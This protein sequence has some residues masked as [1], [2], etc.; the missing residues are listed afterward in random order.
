MKTPHLLLL[1]LVMCILVSC[2]SETDQ[3]KSDIMKSKEELTNSA[4]TSIDKAKTKIDQGQKALDSA[5][6][7]MKRID[8]LSK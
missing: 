5:K 6:E 4:T 2:T 1:G 3:L 7:T 8:E